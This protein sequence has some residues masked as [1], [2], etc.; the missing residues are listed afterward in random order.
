VGSTL[1]GGLLFVSIGLF[2]GNVALAQEP[3]IDFRV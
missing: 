2:A 3:G 1:H